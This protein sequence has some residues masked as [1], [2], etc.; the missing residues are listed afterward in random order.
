MMQRHCRLG[1]WVAVILA[2]G[3]GLA[4]AES[5]YCPSAPK[6]GAYSFPAEA[7]TSLLKQID[8]QTLA[9]QTQH[10]QYVDKLMTSLEPKLKELFET[11]KTAPPPAKPD[12]ESTPTLGIE[13][14]NAWDAM[15]EPMA[16]RGMEQV[17]ADLLDTVRGFM[18]GEPMIPNEPDPSRHSAAYFKD[19]NPRSTFSTTPDLAAEGKSL[20][21]T[22]KQQV[23]TFKQLNAI[24]SKLLKDVNPVSGC[25]QSDIAAIQNSD[26]KGTVT[27]YALTTTPGF[28]DASALRAYVQVTKAY[29]AALFSQEMGLAGEKLVSDHLMTDYLMTT[30]W[31]AADF[32]YFN[33]TPDPLAIAT[34]I[35]N[36][37]QAQ[38]NR[39]DEA[40]SR[41]TR[42]AID[43]IKVARPEFAAAVRIELLR[44][45]API[46]L[47][48]ND[49]T[50]HLGPNV[51]SRA[52]LLEYVSRINSKSE[53]TYGK[54]NIP[55]V[56]HNR[57]P[58][59]LALFDSQTKTVVD[60]PLCKPNVSTAPLF[61]SNEEFES[62]KIAKAQNDN[63]KANNGTS[64]KNPLIKDIDQYI[65]KNGSEITSYPAWLDSGPL[66]C[67]SFKAFANVATNFF[68]LGDGK[69]PFFDWARWG[70]SCGGYPQGVAPA[71]TSW[72]DAL[73]DI[74]TMAWRNIQ[75]LGISV[76][77]AG[78]LP[79]PE[80]CTQLEELKSFVFCKDDPV[81]G[82]I[83]VY[84]G[85]GWCNK[86][87]TKKP[88][89]NPGD[90]D[91]YDQCV[92]ALT[93]FCKGDSWI[94]PDSEK[95]KD[96]EN[97]PKKD[98][99]ECVKKC[100][101]ENNTSP[102]CKLMAA[103]SKQSYG[104]PSLK[105]YFSSK[106]CTIPFDTTDEYKFGNTTII[107]SLKSG[108]LCSS[109]QFIDITTVCGVNGC[110]YTCSSGVYNS[111][112]CGDG[113]ITGQEACDDGN[114]QNGD[115]CSAQC[116]IEAVICGNGKVELL[117]GE[118][119]DDGNIKD[120]DGC[121]VKCQ[122]DFGA[123]GNGKL[124]AVYG[125]N[126]DDGNT[127][128]GDGCSVKCQ[129]EPGVCGNGKLEAAY[130]EDCDDG[131]TKEGDG[132]N[133]KCKKEWCPQCSVNALA[134]CTDFLK[135]NTEALNS[136][137]TLPA[138]YAV[139][140]KTV[141]LA[142]ESCACPI[143]Y[144]SAQCT[145]AQNKCY[146]E[147]K[148]TAG[149]KPASQLPATVCKKWKDM[150]TSPWWWK[151]GLDK[152]P[153]VAK[154][155]AVVR[156]LFIEKGFAK[157]LELLPAVVS[158]AEYNSGMKFSPDNLKNAD[159]H[160]FLA[161]FT[162]T[163]G[164]MMSKTSIAEASLT[165]GEIH[166]SANV[167]QKYSPEAIADSGAHEA[168]HF[169]LYHLGLKEDSLMPFLP[170]EVTAP[171][172]FPLNTKFELYSFLDEFSGEGDH[173]IMQLIQETYPGFNGKPFAWGGTTKDDLCP[174]D[175]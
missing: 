90:I 171:P 49:R 164:V 163:P 128:D 37:P 109:E 23:D 19:S 16:Q 1:V 67:M 2:L 125:E 58:A 115:A 76:A 133:A 53:Y 77:H 96:N 154:E 118:T 59:K 60:V 39:V 31:G 148:K 102:T 162:A 95:S 165:T 150:K 36:M 41:A 124:E 149:P 169:F 111:T 105:D 137:C 18:R 142:G 56:D 123:C 120:G 167:M 42:S 78:I 143:K 168:I 127:K 66:P 126:C 144:S 139:A 72:V 40:L 55:R 48:V 83:D 130:G 106:N 65:P 43:I 29:V 8:D 141:C 4:M 147:C 80:A 116:A 70:M 155:E 10:T 101:P 6:E 74:A 159:R 11:G 170:T 97:T 158:W 104:Y 107:V 152:P 17:P 71:K 51:P 129:F 146:K 54:K 132:C 151:S 3:P 100:A 7:V 32:E 134:E 38:A 63:Y 131:N 75:S 44:A 94:A 108:A 112:V 121:S 99:S 46:L 153:D 64:G 9:T 93:T 22:Y 5:I 68:M 98:V 50:K 114:M 113:S 92:K 85:G 135:L 174:K 140:G 119:C 28:C 156:S 173:F 61:L 81:K 14:T 20:E 69:K 57:I 157:Y 122:F 25:L 35:Y 138:P 52:L 136:E 27:E 47:A 88:P 145:A 103:L 34:V 21:N 175:E 33:S 26:C 161:L 91:W 15:T 160:A 73:K 12:A 86:V 13:E 117:A 84:S 110:V 82:C 62:D 87:W 24:L 79:D 45:M 172:S 166:W 30:P 89:I